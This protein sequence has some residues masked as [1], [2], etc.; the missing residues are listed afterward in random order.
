MKEAIQKYQCKTCGQETEDKKTYLKGYCVTCRL[1]KIKTK[2]MERKLTNVTKFSKHEEIKALL[3]KQKQH[4]TDKS[5]FSDDIS[6]DDNDGDSDHVPETPQN[7]TKKSIIQKKKKKKTSK[8]TPFKKTP[9]KKTPSKVRP[10]PFPKAK[11]KLSPK[12]ENK[13][14]EKNVELDTANLKTASRDKEESCSDNETRTILKFTVKKVWQGTENFFPKCKEFKN[15]VPE[16]FDD[17]EKE[18]WHNLIAKRTS[19]I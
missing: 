3:K 6:Q 14:S 11:I 12:K 4:G 16:I 13:K 17:S 10:L 7:N 8:K 18:L 2:Y 5:D 15:Y 1:L 19:T 9:S